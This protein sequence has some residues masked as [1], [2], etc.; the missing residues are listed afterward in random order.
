MRKYDGGTSLGFREIMAN[1]AF[2][3]TAYYDS[4][5]SGWWNKNLI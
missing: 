5:I 4:V 2:G 1:K 3:L